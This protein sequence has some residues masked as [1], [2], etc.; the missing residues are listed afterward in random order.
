[1]IPFINHSLPE[2]HSRLFYYVNCT[3]FLTDLQ[4]PGS[5]RQR[6]AAPLIHVFYSLKKFYS[7]AARLFLSL[8]CSFFNLSC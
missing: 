5:R 7:G 4:Q 6:D 1:M 8:N 3:T 2:A